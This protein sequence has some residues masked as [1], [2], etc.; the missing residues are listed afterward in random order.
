[1]SR[2]VVAAEHEV[3]ED[4]EA[5]RVELLVEIRAIGER[6]RQVEGRIERVGRP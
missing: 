4:V 3:E 1:L 5:A 6:L 2:E